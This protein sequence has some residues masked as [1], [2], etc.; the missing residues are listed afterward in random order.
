[1][2]FDSVF[3]HI[4]GAIFFSLESKIMKVDFIIC[5]NSDLWYSECVEIF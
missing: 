4:G 1:M 2:N 3:K 5:I